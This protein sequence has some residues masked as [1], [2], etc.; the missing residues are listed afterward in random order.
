MPSVQVVGIHHRQVNRLLPAIHHQPQ[1][2]IIHK[3]REHAAGYRSIREHHQATGRNPRRK[4][5]FQGWQLF[6]AVTALHIVIHCAKVEHMPQVVAPRLV[7]RSIEAGFKA[8][9]VL[10][11]NLRFHFFNPSAPAPAHPPAPG[12]RID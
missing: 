4:R 2:C 12:V 11:I 3:D 9:A 8:I 10:E 1:V 6:H 7:Q 5:H